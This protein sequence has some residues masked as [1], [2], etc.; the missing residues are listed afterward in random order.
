MGLLACF[1]L[2]G[3]K[4]APKEETEAMEE[5]TFDLA[6]AKQEIIDANKVFMERFNAGDST[7]VA[8]LYATDGK[9][10]MNGAPAI[11]GRAQIQSTLHGL[12]GSGV[13]RVDLTTIDVWGTEDMVTEEGELAL[14]A[15]D[16]QVDQGKYLVLWKNIDGK[17]H[18]FR[19]CFNSNM[20][21]KE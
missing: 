11:V 10:M 21:P 6:M 14:Y 13:S 1:V 17:W 12:I 15:G 7:G 4:E 2:V 3:C 9:I 5:P 18:L 16:Q 20:P 19:D 8:N